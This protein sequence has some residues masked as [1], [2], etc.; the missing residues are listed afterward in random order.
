MKIAKQR[1]LASAQ[2]LLNHADRVCVLA[3]EDSYHSLV[4]QERLAEF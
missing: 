2:E 4:S 1:T 3:V